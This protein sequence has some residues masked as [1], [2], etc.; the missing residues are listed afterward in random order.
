MDRSKKTGA[1]ALANGEVLKGHDFSRAAST[2]QKN[3]GL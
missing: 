2:D 3:L 1:L